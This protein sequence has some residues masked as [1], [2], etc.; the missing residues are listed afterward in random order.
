MPH[1]PKKPCSY[2]R[3]PELTTE[4]YCME[5]QEKEQESKA[6]R[7][8]RY[9]TYKRD[10][11]LIQFYKGKAWIKLRDIV[12]QREHG[13]CQRCLRENLFKK[14]DVVHHIVEVKEDWDRRLDPDNLESLCHRCHNQE[15]HSSSDAELMGIFD[16]GR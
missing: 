2:P 14:A 10:K 11:K 3:C 16:G 5:H 6:E 8:K 7:N 9:D 15:H 4:R 13:L 12:Y 1:K